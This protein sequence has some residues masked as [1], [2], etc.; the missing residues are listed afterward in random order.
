MTYSFTSPDSIPYPEPGT[1]IADTSSS[2]NLTNLL[3]RQATVTQI[4]LSGR[5]SVTPRIR[6]SVDGMN[7]DNLI[8]PSWF[9]WHT[10]TSTGGA[11]PLPVGLNNRAGLFI[12]GYDIYN[13]VQVLTGRESNVSWQRTCLEPNATPKVWTAWRSSIGANGP[14]NGRDLNEMFRLVDFGMW[15]FDYT[16]STLNMPSG[17]VGKGILN[18]YGSGEYTVV[19]EV[20]SRE[21]NIT[22]TR[23]GTNLGTT[24]PVWSVWAITGVPGESSRVQLG[25]VG[26]S[27]VASHNLVPSL[28]AALPGIYCYSRGWN[29]ETTD[30]M[31]LRLG[32]KD[33]WW[34]VSGGVIPATGS[35]AV[36][37]AQSLQVMDA[38]TYYTGM[39]AGVPG[40]INKTSTAFTFV[41]DTDGTAVTVDKPV[42]L[43]PT[44]T[45]TT[46]VHMLGILAGRNDVSNDD[47][48]VDGTIPKHIVANTERLVDWLLPETKLF[49]LLGTINRMSEP[50]GS[51]GYEAVVE[52]NSL[53]DVRWP[54]KR[55]DLR[56]YLVNQCIYDL[57]ITPTSAD[58][59]NIAND[60]PPPSVMVD[61]THYTDQ[62]ATAIVNNLI[63]PWLKGNGYVAV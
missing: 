23:T 1:K 63:V 17:L 22:W 20:T 9:G 58:L 12:H 2:E 32:A 18:V 55:I 39:L 11:T 7:L 44:W 21:Q 14:C 30:G 62:A 27:L 59:A 53:L 46:R 43:E 37:T 26:D 31:T 54:S 56:G 60:C 28:T 33:Y 6:G 47:A 10:L 16:S 4:A 5:D 51:A 38:D 57:G 13:T 49:F 42:K 61:D 25:M 45:Q 8:G 19:Q 35:V 52:T 41:R 29:G 3:Q 34:N 24:P 40:R 36:T 15:D 48:G 50:A